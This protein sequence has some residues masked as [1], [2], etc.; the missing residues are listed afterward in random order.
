MKRTVQFAL[1]AVAVLLA[2]GIT[3]YP[4]IANAYTERNRSLSMQDNLLQS[5]KYTN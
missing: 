3:L 5:P 4:L 1:L 2:I